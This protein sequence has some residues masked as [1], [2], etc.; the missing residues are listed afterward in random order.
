[1]KNVLVSRVSGVLLHLS[2]LGLAE[3]Y[4]KGSQVLSH[5]WLED[6]YA[7]VIE[8]IIRKSRDAVQAGNELRAMQ[9]LYQRYMADEGLFVQHSTNGLRLYLQVSGHI[10]PLSSEEKQK[11]ILA[12]LKS[13]SSARPTY[14]KK[15]LGFHVTGSLRKMLNESILV[16]KIVGKHALYSINPDI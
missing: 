10:N 1:M 14:M 5:V 11:R 12:Y 7:E 16:E 3:S 15:D 9:A 4:Y 13:H 8:E 2:N 6:D